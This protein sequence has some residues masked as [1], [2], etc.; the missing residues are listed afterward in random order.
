VL[1]LVEVKK[2]KKRTHASA[3]A[4]SAREE[5]HHPRTPVQARQRL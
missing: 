1:H 5:E 2:T 3:S 4:P